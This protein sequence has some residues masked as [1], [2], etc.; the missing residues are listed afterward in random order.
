MSKQAGLGTIV[1]SVFAVRNEDGTINHDAS[2]AK[3]SGVLLEYEVQQEAEESAL[4]NA[5]REFFDAHKTVRVN[6]PYV[7]SK[8]LQMMNAGPDNH[9]AL[10]EK[11]EA[12]IK[13]N[14][15]GK[16]ADDGTVER[17]N[18][19]LVT[20]KGRGDLGGCARRCDIVEKTEP[21]KA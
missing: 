7:K 6:M 8:I 15:Q 13:R 14:S 17:P 18:S 5:V 11:L 10:T 3:F 4:A 2:N 21:V 20:S 19:L 16:K 1:F 12:Y 9:A